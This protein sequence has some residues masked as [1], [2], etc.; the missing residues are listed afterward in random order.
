[1]LR[2]FVA[3]VNEAVDDGFNRGLNLFMENLEEDLAKSEI[4]AEA[5]GVDTVIAT[6]L[7]ADGY[8]VSVKDEDLENLDESKIDAML[9]HFKKEGIN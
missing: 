2:E 5:G 8:E 3:L 7:E 1:M 9:D 6:I 4:I